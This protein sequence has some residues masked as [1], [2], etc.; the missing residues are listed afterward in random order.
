VSFLTLFAKRSRNS[1]KEH[2]GDTTL[3]R[4]LVGKFVWKLWSAVAGRNDSWV[5][6][7]PDVQGWHIIRSEDH[8]FTISGML[9]V[10]TGVLSGL[11]AVS[12]TATISE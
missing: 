8:R 10:I 9:L 12:G 3:I 6:R 11:S 4:K 2:K 7:L 1:Q 5:R